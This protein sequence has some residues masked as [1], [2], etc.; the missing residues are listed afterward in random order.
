MAPSGTS[1]ASGDPEMEELVDEDGTY[2]PSWVPLCGG[3]GSFG[4]GTYD[5]PSDQ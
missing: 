5:H 3:Y 4:G 1:P 2:S